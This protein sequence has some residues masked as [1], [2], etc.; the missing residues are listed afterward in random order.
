MVPPIVSPDVANGV[1]VTASFLDKTYVGV[2]ASIAEA[3]VVIAPSANADNVA[4]AT[5]DLIRM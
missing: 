5:T 4:R 1:M 3:L 2:A